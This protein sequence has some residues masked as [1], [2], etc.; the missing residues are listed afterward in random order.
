MDSRY[1]A[2]IIESLIY[3]CIFDIAEE[4]VGETHLLAF[5]SMEQAAYKYNIKLCMTYI[6]RLLDIPEESARVIHLA[7]SLEMVNKRP[8]EE[9]IGNRII[10]IPGLNEGNVDIV[11]TEARS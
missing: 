7:F 2:V 5:S 8:G 1:L 10:V 9:T 4:S 11:F 6:C 3:R